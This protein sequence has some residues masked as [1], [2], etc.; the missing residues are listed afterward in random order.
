LIVFVLIE[1]VLTFWIHDS[2]LL[3][4]LMLIRPVGAIKLWQMCQ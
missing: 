4:I 1:V 3:Q 2:L